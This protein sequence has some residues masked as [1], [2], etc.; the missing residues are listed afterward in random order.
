M[1]QIESKIRTLVDGDGDMR[2]AIETVLDRA[3]DGDV[4]WL[5][6]KSELSSGQWGRLIEKGVL[7]EGE[8]G[9]R[10]ADAEATDDEYGEVLLQS[11]S[12]LRHS[13]RSGA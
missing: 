2:D 10:L 1:P 3:D 7:V 6:V 4:R 5:D 13:L 8:E 9:F 11:S 12:L